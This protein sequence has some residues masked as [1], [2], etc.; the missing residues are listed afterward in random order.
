MGCTCPQVLNAFRHHW[1]LHL[2][3]C[4]RLRS[5]PRVL[6]AFRHHW[7]LHNLVAAG[8]GCV[9]QCSTPF[10]IIG[11]FTPSCKARMSAGLISCSTPFGIIGIFTS[12]A[13]STTARS[14]SAQRLSASLESSHRI[15]EINQPHVAC[16]TPFGIIGIFTNES[17]PGCRRGDGA[18]RLSASLESSPGVNTHISDPQTRCS[19]PFG[20]I[21]I[22]TPSPESSSTR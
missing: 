7:N 22:F 17:A 14:A 15:S 12:R 9:V 10:G 8:Y 20:I 5:L 16:S 3:A 13:C 2:R 18:Q 4:R 1:N 19:T 21:G 6:N 11:I